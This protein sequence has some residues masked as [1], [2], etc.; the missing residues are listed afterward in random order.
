V[1]MDGVLAVD[2]WRGLATAVIPI[3]VLLLVIGRDGHLGDAT[4]RANGTPTAPASG[5]VMAVVPMAQR[6]SGRS[7]LR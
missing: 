3:Q 1:P 7:S 2:D 4:R 6:L 5:P